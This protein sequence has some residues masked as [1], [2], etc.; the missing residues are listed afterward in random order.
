[1][2]KRWAIV[3]TMTVIVVI[4][5]SVF[6]ATVISKERGPFYL[7]VT[8]GGDSIEEAK[9]LIDKVKDYTNTFVFTSF[10][11]MENVT[12]ITEIGDY[13]VNAGLN[14][15]IYYGNIGPNTDYSQ[16]VTRLA[17]QR[18]N[19]S[20]LGLYF[21]D[22]P[23]GRMIDSTQ[24]NLYPQDMNGS[25]TRDNDGSVT[26]RKYYDTQT[27]LNYTTPDNKTIVEN[28]GVPRY[29]STNIS[30][31]FHPSGVIDYYESVQFFNEVNATTPPEVPFDPSTPPENPPFTPI[32]VQINKSIYYY[33]NGT[34]TCNVMYSNGQ[35]LTID[36]GPYTYQPDGTVLDSK[37][38]PTT[39]SGTHAQFIPYET[40]LQSNPLKDYANTANTFIEIKE[41][42][43]ESVKTNMSE[44]NVLTSDYALYWFD[45]QL[46]YDTVLAQ[47]VGNESRER[48]IAL[49]RGAADT[50]GGDWGAIITWKYNQPPY[51][52]SGDEL[53][54]DLA[55]AYSAG[56][57][58]GIVFTYP[59]MTTYGTLTD[60]HFEA[61][62]RFWTTM[63][64]DPDSFGS[65][66]AK[67]AYV[68]PAD[69]GFGFRNA[70]DKIWGL[71]EADEHSQ[72]IYDDTIFLTGKYGAGLNILYD[73]P[74]TAAKLDGYQQVYYYNQT[75][76]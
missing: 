65:N 66:P 42:G 41:K 7:G 5:V 11:L 34:I 75:V 12:A 17:Q 21:N 15:I 61:L 70:N 54:A 13:A 24:A 14:V 64:D 29:N 32:I 52:E 44:L 31:T 23:G 28:V 71:W 20:F 73:G 63:H 9:L 56:A 62:Q 35:Q 18:W 39:A 72:K 76:T 50:L 48:H 58:Y 27:N 3:L 36:T 16:N 59:N 67:A 51:L 30:T 38:A 74:E 68:V 6:A 4:V 46:G 57:K 1:M 55:V 53:F 2:K 60:E 47:F 8:Y 43:V 40:L 33:P 49:C 37:G 19:S 26:A 10:N 45:Y 25:V 22:E 69:Y